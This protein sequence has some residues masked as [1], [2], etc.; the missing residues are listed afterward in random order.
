MKPILGFLIAP[1]VGVLLPVFL[2]NIASYQHDTFWPSVIIYLVV[3][4][5]VAY[6]SAL[7]LGVPLFLLFRRLGW[8]RLWQVIAGSALCG[9]PFAVLQFLQT[10]MIY[11]PIELSVRWFG[12]VLI[13]SVLAGLAFWL[14]ALRHHN[15]P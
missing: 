14:V 9:I 3:A 7:V 13:F 11:A 12:S 1:P 8:L 2:I 6:A 4:V 10:K 5:T 15:E